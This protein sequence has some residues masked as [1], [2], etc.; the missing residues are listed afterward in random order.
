MSC[1]CGTTNN[2]WAEQS[3]HMGRQTLRCVVCGSPRGGFAADGN[4]YCVDHM[5]P[6]EEIL[7]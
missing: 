4:F 3:P 1:D 2:Y 6:G 5:L 7:S